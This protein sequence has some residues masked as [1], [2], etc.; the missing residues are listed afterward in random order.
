M[1]K[2]NPY[3]PG[4]FGAVV[5]G[6]EIAL[7]GS[8]D[9]DHEEHGESLKRGQYVRLVIHG[10]ITGV[11]EVD[12]HTEHRDVTIRKWAVKASTTSDVRVIRE[13]E[14]RT[15]PDGQ[16]AGQ[17]SMSVTLTPERAAEQLAALEAGRAERDGDA[18]PRGD[19]LDAQHAE[20][21]TLAIDEAAE[22]VVP[23]GSEWLDVGGEVVV[24]VLGASAIEDEHTVT[25]APDG[26]ILVYPDS[27]FLDG[28][29]KLAPAAA[30]EQAPAEHADEHPGEDALRADADDPSRG[31]V[32]AGTD[33]A[34]VV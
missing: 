34:A 4:A 31:P 7:S 33:P 21:A 17:T 27:S 1:S 25:R 22:T 8:V 19:G 29:L 30:P 10:Y 20:S 18:E 15:R 32:P 12:K 6:E 24:T 2:D 3:T 13:P 14:P 28:K 11:G 23:K 5:D 16:I 9:Y 26:E